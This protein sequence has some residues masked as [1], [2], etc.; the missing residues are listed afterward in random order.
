MAIAEKNITDARDRLFCRFSDRIKTNVSLSRKLVSYQ[1]NKAVPGLRWLKYKEG[2]SAE[3]VESLLDSIEAQSLL[4]PF[5]GSGTAP[6]TAGSLGMN[7]LGIEVM[8]IGTLLARSISAVSNG[9]RREDLLEATGELIGALERTPYDPR[10][11]FPH[12]PITERAF[13]ERT[14]QDLA[15]ARG[16]LGAVTDRSLNTVLSLACMS[17]LEEISYTRKDGQFLRWDPQSGRDVKPKLNKGSLPMLSDALRR[18]IGEIADDFEALKLK[19]G[20]TSPSSKGCQTR[21]LTW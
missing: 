3:L 5:A 19:Y 6:L 15:K 7:S 1:G 9:L 17:V 14:E 4:D 8:P 2:F 10:L 16:F 11:V 21:P 12:I 18:R 20:G 13:P